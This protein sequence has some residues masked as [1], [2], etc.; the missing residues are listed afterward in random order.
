MTSGDS[1]RRCTGRSRGARRRSSALESPQSRSG[2]LKSD[3]LSLCSGG[4][5]R[6]LLWATFPALA[7]LQNRAIKRKL[8]DLG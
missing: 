7:G 4:R 1:T 5:S 8:D 6:A 3:S 2:G